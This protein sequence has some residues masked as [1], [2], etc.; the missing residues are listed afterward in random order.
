MDWFWTGLSVFLGDPSVARNREIRT[1]RSE[2]A[3][4]LNVDQNTLT[5]IAVSICLFG[6]IAQLYVV[7]NVY[8]VILTDM[9]SVGLR[10][11]K[12]SV[13]IAQLMATAIMTLLR[14]V[15]RRDLVLDE[16]QREE[17]PKGYELDWSA[18]R[19]TDCATWRMV[20]WGHMLTPDHQLSPE[21]HAASY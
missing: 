16:V 17:L 19:L 4:S 12:W 8:A 18:K 3:T 10:G 11:L 20:T 14:V 21:G 1:T 9:N 2:K 5:I 15:F 7:K 13:T 6:F